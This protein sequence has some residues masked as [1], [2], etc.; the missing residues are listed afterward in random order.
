MRKSD[1][2]QVGLGGCGCSSLGDCKPVFTSD[3][4]I[5]CKAS[6]ICIGSCGLAVTIGGASTQLIMY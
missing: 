3:G 1:G 6:G 5:V 2:L 4:I